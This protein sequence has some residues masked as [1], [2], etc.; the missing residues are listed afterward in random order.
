MSHKERYL[1]A[2]NLEQPDIVPID[3]SFMD[4]VHMEK[5]TGKKAIGSGGGGGGG[6]WALRPEDLEIDL[7]K[8][9]IENQR[10]TIDA[11]KKIGLDSFSVS[12][13]W[14][15]PKGYRHKFLN[16]DTYV[17]HWGK[18][19]EVRKDV[20][21][22]Y[23]V[24]GT[25][26]NPDDLN[27]FVPPDPDELCYDV[28]DFTIEEA[29][30]EYPV[31][32][33]GHCANMFPY[34]MRGGIDKLTYDI[35]RNP[36]FAKKLIKIVADTNFEIAKNML[37]R[38]IDIFV[39]S[40]DI[41]YTKST[42]F[43]PR[44]YKEFFFPYL[45]RLIDECHRRGVPFMKHSDGNLYPILDELI[46]LGID[47]LHPIEPGAMNL[48]DVKRKY[49]D[50]IFLRGNVD[51]MHILPYGTEGDVRKEVRRCIDEAAEDGGFI[52]SDSNS[53]HSNIE[54]RNILIMIDEGR[55]YGRYP[56]SGE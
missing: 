19:Y 44:I 3:A 49:G 54:T 36:I 5:I 14:L 4:L 15:F 9:M 38:G 45:K 56:I 41:A 47:G 21:T 31:M 7:N 24:D 48:A 16:D 18:M 34:L 22:T 50:K 51:C 52:L 20:K 1:T 40:D 55:K 28:I 35:Y 8:A 27:K 2:V 33:W 25:I 42:F 53:M 17:D 37:D 10:I 46:S 11:I 30:D 32:A 6:A 12:D 39:E 23:W 43:P 29:G 26:K 13:Y